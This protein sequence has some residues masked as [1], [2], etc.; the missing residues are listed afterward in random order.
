MEATKIRYI[1]DN[2][3]I[4]PVQSASKHK[5]PPQHPSLIL[6][7]QVS[8][9]SHSSECGCQGDVCIAKKALWIYS[10]N[11]EIKDTHR[12]RDVAATESA[13]FR[14]LIHDGNGRQL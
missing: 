14:N 7:D 1:K 2:I 3:Y 5:L 13:L 4:P 11:G 8:D 9:L 10:P 12:T 6:A